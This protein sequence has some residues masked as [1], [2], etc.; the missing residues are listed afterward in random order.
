MFFFVDG[1]IKQ[2][3]AQMLVIFSFSLKG[4]AWA[5]KNVI[6][7]GQDCYSNIKSNGYVYSIVPRLD[8]LKR[9]SFMGIY[10]RFACYGLCH[11]AQIWKFIMISSISLSML[12]N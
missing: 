10:V 12:F 8:E 2:Y 4:T 5:V 11:S 6:Y 9:A 1:S 3:K 7:G